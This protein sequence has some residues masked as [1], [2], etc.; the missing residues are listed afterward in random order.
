[1]LIQNEFDKNGL[2]DYSNEFRSLSQ[3]K[4]NSKQVTRSNSIAIFGLIVGALSLVVAL[5]QIFIR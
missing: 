1:M 4:E 5:I 2:M 3:Q